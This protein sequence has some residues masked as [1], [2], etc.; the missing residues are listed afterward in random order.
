MSKN[1]EQEN[2][3]LMI[4]L[5]NK[6][7]MYFY[8]V[9]RTDYEFGFRSSKKDKS[10]DFHIKRKSNTN[11]NTHSIELTFTVFYE[12]VVDILNR[13]GKEHDTENISDE[14]LDKI[15]YEISD[16]KYVGIQALYIRP[17]GTGL[18]QKLIKEFIEI[19]RG[20]DKLEKIYLSPDGNYAKRFLKKIGFTQNDDFDVRINCDSNMLFNLK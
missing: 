5:R 6:L 4:N 20:I 7:D 9:L 8:N 3:K 1:K 19:I 2:Y 11:K 17:E 14:E 15:L 13:Y 16:I 12:D 18:G 10:Y